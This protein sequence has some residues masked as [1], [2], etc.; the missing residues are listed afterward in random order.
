MNK[1]NDPTLNLI[2]L[3]EECSEVIQEVSKVLRFGLNSKHPR[4]GPDNRSKLET[5]CGHTLALIN[6]LISNGVIS[7]EKVNGAI[8]PKL[9]KMAAFYSVADEVF[10]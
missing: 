1:L 2:I 6:L 4:G 10:H 7:E 9:E 5:E 3:S 8:A